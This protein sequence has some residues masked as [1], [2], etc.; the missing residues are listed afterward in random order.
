M[1]TRVSPS[2]RRHP[3]RSACYGEYRTLFGVL[4]F[5]AF[6]AL[7]SPVKSRASLELGF[8]LVT[9]WGRGNPIFGRTSERWEL[10][11]DVPATLD[12]PADENPRTSRNIQV[13]NLGRFVDL[14]AA[15]VHR[16]PRPHNL[17]CLQV[18]KETAI[19]QS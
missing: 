2:R 12:T 18:L 4:E 11:H 1:W 14:R 15:S 8:L 5:P 10:S 6:P 7:S 3:R 13:L 17:S 16:R 9:Y 19:A